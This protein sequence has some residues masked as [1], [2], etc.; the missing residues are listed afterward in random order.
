MKLVIE[1]EI[2]LN[3]QV[4][5]VWE[6]LTNS[7]WTK[8]YMFG[9][10]VFSEWKTGD[11]IVWKTN[12]KGKEYVRR[13]KVLRIEPYEILKISDFNPNAGLEDIDSNYAKVTYRLVS[14]SSLKTILKIEDDCAG[15]E[16]R[17]EESKQFWEIVLLKLKEVLEEK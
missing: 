17:Y 12:I 7:K 8:Q 6:A 15:D 4:S 1:K 14:E 5:K 3:V 9:Y 13:G 2:L 16:K 11:S 10:E